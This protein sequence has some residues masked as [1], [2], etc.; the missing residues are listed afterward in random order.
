MTA[1]NPTPSNDE[2]CRKCGKFKP[3]SE[4]EKPTKY[5]HSVYCIECKRLKNR[6]SYIRNRDKRLAKHG[7]YRK[8]DAGKQTIS[9]AIK[10]ANRLHPEKNT[11][12]LKLRYAVSRGKIMK[13]P[14]MTCGETKVEAHHYAGYEPE[15]WYKVHWLCRK[16]HRDTHKFTLESRGLL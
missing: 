3:L 2:Q 5:N 7:A 15:N 9:R 14:C 16:H 12:R 1:P 10:K 4:F 13:A 8:S 6:E 11:A